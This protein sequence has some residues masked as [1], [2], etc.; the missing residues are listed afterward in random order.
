M[1]TLKGPAVFFCLLVT[2]FVVGVSQFLLARPQSQ[3]SQDSLRV[4]LRGYLEN[5]SSGEDRTTQYAAVATDLNGDGTK[6]VVVYVTGRSWCGSGGCTM[7]VIAPTESTYRVIA[8]VPLVR[9][10]IRMLT[11]RSNGWRDLGV[12][13]EGGGVRPGHEALLHMT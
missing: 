9:L 6:E 7:L 13:V 2:L 12:W 8:R 11:S 1:P 5:L 10:P 3:Q 4:F